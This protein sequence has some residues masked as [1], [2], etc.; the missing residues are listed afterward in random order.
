M[1]TAASTVGRSHHGRGVT[2]SRL[3]GRRHTHK[4]PSLRAAQPA[5]DS[6]APVPE[7]FQPSRRQREAQ[8]CRPAEARPHP[9]G[10]PVGA[11]LQR[12]PESVCSLG[13]GGGRRQSFLPHLGSLALCHSLACAGGIAER[14]HD[15]Q[16]PPQR[17]LGRTPNFTQIPRVGSGDGE[18]VLVRTDPPTRPRCVGARVTGYVEEGDICLHASHGRPLVRAPH[19]SRF[20]LEKERNNSFWKYCVFLSLRSVYVETLQKKLKQATLVFGSRGQAYRAPDVAG[21]WPDGGQLPAVPGSRLWLAVGQRKK[22]DAD[23]G[24]PHSAFKAHASTVF[25][26]ILILVGMSWGRRGTSQPLG[27]S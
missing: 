13:R 9:G 10:S 20:V 14:T 4:D 5:P 23:L 16:T 3:P 12:L 18:P 6:P 26:E 21:P 25:V 15:V 7:P 17:V 2:G 22:I 19:S 11:V 27:G 1:A 8:A 24:M